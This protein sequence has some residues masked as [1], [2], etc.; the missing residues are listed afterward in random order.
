M[1][2]QLRSLLVVAFTGL[3]IVLRFDAYRFG[4]AEY[5]DEL[6]PGGWRTGAR[7]FTWYAIGLVL[8]AAIYLI[9]PRPIGVLHL[10]LGDDRARAILLGFGLGLVGTAV[11]VAFA[12]FRYGGFRLP[13]W[14]HYP[15]AVMNAAFTAL[16]D[17]VA[18][19]GALLGMLLALTW[20]PG[21]AIAFQALLYALATRLGAPGRSRFFLLLSLGV[22]VV[23][24]W[25]TLVTGG[26]GAAILAHAITRVAIFVCTG[27]AGL[28]RAPGEEPEEEEAERLP[29][30][31][32]RVVRDEDRRR[33]DRWGSASENER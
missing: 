1:E 30:A 11:A 31:G 6:A 27:H 2:E 21:L 25:A 14:V 12:W 13:Q 17:E 7:R 8:V 29:P 10:T 19:R 9:H 33:S 20:P 4:A 28:V 3:L 15:G 24:G 16:I 18:F 5:D 23:T 26:I 22:G 32:W